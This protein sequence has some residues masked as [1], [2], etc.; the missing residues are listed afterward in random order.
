MFTTKVTSIV[1]SLFD[2]SGQRPSKREGLTFLSSCGLKSPTIGKDEYELDL[3]EASPSLGF[4]LLGFWRQRGSFAP[5]ARLF[6][7]LLPTQP[8]VK[9]ATATK[10]RASN[11]LMPSSSSSTTLA[12]N[13]TC[14]AITTLV[15]VN[16]SCNHSITP[17]R[18]FCTARNIPTAARI[19][20][21]PSG[22]E[23][24]EEFQER[25]F[26]S[27]RNRGSFTFRRLGSFTL[28]FLTSHETKSDPT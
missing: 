25:G 17:G 24:R 8:M 3:E 26:L 9:T 15:D 23:P 6:F 16:W 12:V 18:Y 14:S 19:K 4:P 1:G 27:T 7:S 21:A 10:R 5:A 20:S 13:G 28:P 11:R 2:A 22:D